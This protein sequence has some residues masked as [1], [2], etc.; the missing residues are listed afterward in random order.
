MDIQFIEEEKLVSKEEGESTERLRLGEILIKYDM[1]DGSQIPK[2]LEKQKELGLRFGEAILAM[3][4][5]TEDQINWALAYHLDIPYVDLTPDMVDMPLVQSFPI[6]LLKQNMFV[7]LVRYDKEITVV[8]AD[9][10]LTQAVADIRSITGCE[11]KVSVALRERIAAILDKLAVK[12]ETLDLDII[13]TNEFVPQKGISSSKRKDITEDTS[14]LAF[15]HFHL[16]HAVNHHANEIHI[17]P[18]ED[19]MRI[20]YRIYGSLREVKSES[21]SVHYTVVNRLKIMTDLPVSE[22]MPQTTHLKIKIGDKNL[23]VA[24]SMVPGLWGESIVMRILQHLDP[25]ALDK[26]DLSPDDLTDVQKYLDSMSG[27]IVVSGPVAEARQRLLYTLLN[28]AKSTNRRIITIE[29]PVRQHLDFA[30]QIDLTEH[31][32]FNASDVLRMIE[33]QS[34]DII[35]IG[36]LDREG[37]DLLPLLLENSLNGRLVIVG[38]PY[39]DVYHAFEYLTQHVPSLVPLA[40]KLQFILAQNVF[41]RLSDNKEAYQP[42]QHMLDA[43]NLSV[44]GDIKFYRPIAGKE[45]KTSGYSGETEIYDLLC[46]TPQFKDLLFSKTTMQSQGDQHKIREFFANRG[47]PSLREQALQRVLRGELFIDDVL[48]RTI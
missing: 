24:V 16:M 15:I 39:G 32:K 12:D 8:M 35:M 38:L 25:A 11:V 1:L 28:H 6:K 33:T 13:T 30:T 7:P 42:P 9:P 31:R 4:L 20:R 40:A 22:V 45:L 26:I 5:L 17:E 47:K 3:A 18:L 21:S 44:T 48:A 46:M 10:T 37:G 29:N 41:P 19:K 23:T 36:R 14:G 27:F 2:I 43:A 34:P